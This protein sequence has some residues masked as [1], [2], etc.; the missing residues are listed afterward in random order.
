M[1][2]DEEDEERADAPRPLGIT[3]QPTGHRA[4]DA[5]LDRLAAADDL[6]VPAHLEVYEDVH[7]GLRDTLTALDQPQPPGPPAPGPRPGGPGRH[8]HDPRS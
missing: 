2:E 7:R 1:E 8:P 6:P 3:V 4:V 5:R